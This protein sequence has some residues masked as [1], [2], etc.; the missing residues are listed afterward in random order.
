MS[1]DRWLS[2]KSDLLEDV[3][4]Y[5]FT[6][7]VTQ[8]SVT[9]EIPVQVEVIA[10]KL[11]SV[12]LFEDVMYGQY[13]AGNNSQLY[14]LPGYLMSPNCDYEVDFLTIRGQL[15]DGP[16]VTFTFDQSSLQLV[17]QHKVE[18]SIPTDQGNQLIG[19]NFTLNLTLTF[20]DVFLQRFDRDIVFYLFIAEPNSD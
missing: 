8:G 10:C 9:A 5:T 12:T 18:I 7:Q 15:T 11:S 14:S 6:L 4:L 1:Q 16:D 3:G 2:L 13:F 19:T 17:P 20:V